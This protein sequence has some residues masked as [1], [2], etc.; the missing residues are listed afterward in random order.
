MKTTKENRK[1][2]INKKSK[3]WKLHQPFG[4]FATFIDRLPDAREVQQTKLRSAPR[5]LT[6]MVF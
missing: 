2:R 6:G 4:E 1:I 3:Q 5:S